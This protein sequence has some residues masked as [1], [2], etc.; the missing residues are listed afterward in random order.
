M[1]TSFQ[2]KGGHNDRAIPSMQWLPRERSSLGLV[3]SRERPSQELPRGDSPWAEGWVGDKKSASSKRAEEA[4]E[5]QQSVSKDR[6]VQGRVGC[7][8]NCKP[9]SITRVHMWKWEEESWRSC[10]SPGLREHVCH[11]EELGCWE[12]LE[13]ITPPSVSFPVSCRQDSRKSSSSERG[14]WRRGTSWL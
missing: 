5:L 11:V 14:G 7:A 2:N 6:L 3:W 12:H 9:F 1:N 10:R 4:S 13:S 8:R